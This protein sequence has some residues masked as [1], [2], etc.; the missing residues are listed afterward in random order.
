MPE[1]F[2]NP[3]GEQRR[4]LEG[5]AYVAR[6][7]QGVLEISGPDAKKWLHS[8]LSQDILNLKPG[9]S[10]EALLLTPQGHIEQ[11]LKIIARDDDLLVISSKKLQPQLISWLERMKFRS[12]VQISQSDLAVFGTF[13]EVVGDIWID[14]FASQ[15]AK[16]ARYSKRPYDFAYRE[17]VAQEPPELEQVGMMAYQALRIAAGRPEMTDVDERS[18]PHEYDWLNSAVHLSK[19]CYRGQEA[20]AKVHNLGHPPRRTVLLHFESGDMLAN[21]GDEVFYQDKPAGKVLAGALH[22]ELGSIALALV[23]RATPY[24]DLRVLSSGSEYQA[25]QE[26]LVPADAG[27]AANLPR[28]S[29]FKLSGKK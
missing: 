14:S 16:S 18:L 21:P 28:P 20:V 11:Q 22:F 25:T 26:V 19:G 1:H 8:L 24:L 15:N 23:S 3:L 29:A 6:D 27:K 5:N 2:G 4:L 10:T 13:A 17:L 7:D 9:D 12:Q